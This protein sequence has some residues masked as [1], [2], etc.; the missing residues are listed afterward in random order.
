[1]S[2]WIIP[3]L[4]VLGVTAA[5]VAFVRTPRERRYRGFSPVTLEEQVKN[6]PES[7]QAVIIKGNRKHALARAAPFILVGIVLG[8][9]AWWIGNTNHP[10]CVRL[11]GVNAVYLSLL[12][13][14]YGLPVIFL[15]M[16]ILL[17]GTGIKTLKTGYFPP[18]DAVVF[19][20]TIAQK[21]TVSRIRG[22]VLVMLPA[23]ALLGVYLGNSAFTA[24]AGDRSMH[25]IVGKLEAKCQ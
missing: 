25:E 3:A 17:L 8:C 5:V 7:A 14:C 9:F 22:I 18:L 1:M 16:S 4:A 13:V 24:V 19:M 21:G 12:I 6:C 11:L 15:A 10:A 2:A 23:F 20:D